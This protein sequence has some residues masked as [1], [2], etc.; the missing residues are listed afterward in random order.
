MSHEI[1]YRFGFDAAHHFD[2]FPE[3]HPNRTL[4]GH[5]F[6]VEIAIA[7]R[8]DPRTGFI[9]EFGG[10]AEACA[11]VR[12]ALDHKTLNAIAGLEKPSLEHLSTWIW[13]H[14]K[15]RFPQLVRVTVRRDSC[16]QACTYT[17]P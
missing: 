6:G 7:G 8:P 2:H 3:G 10:V 11:G 4:H 12:S 13:E 14:L 16:G 9:E 1:S 17:G 5:S 15:P